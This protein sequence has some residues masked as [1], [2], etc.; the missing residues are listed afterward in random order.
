MLLPC[1]DDGDLRCIGSRQVLTAHMR[2]FAP[3]VFPT[4]CSAP[5][6]KGLSREG[7]TRMSLAQ[8]QPG[9]GIRV[10]RGRLRVVPAENG[11][12]SRGV[13]GAGARDECHQPLRRVVDRFA[14]RALGVARAESSGGPPQLA[15]RVHGLHGV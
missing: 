3:G 1:A 8:R 7:Q 10:C 11:L 9:S 4:R 14:G 6:A 15:P 12:D 13:S 2:G 5:F